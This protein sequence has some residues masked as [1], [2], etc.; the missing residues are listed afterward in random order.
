[1]REGKGKMKKKRSGRDE[2]L[3]ERRCQI[4]RESQFLY[5]SS[6]HNVQ[7]AILPDWGVEDLLQH[8]PFLLSQSSRSTSGRSEENVEE[9]LPKS[10]SL[11]LP[12]CLLA[13]AWRIRWCKGRGEFVCSPPPPLSLTSI[14]LSLFSPFFYLCHSFVRYLVFEVG[15]GEI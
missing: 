5:I 12:I 7:S 10:R 2:N 3:R 14:Y 13:G 15:S 8:S 9:N 11:L 1:M 4:S 6:W